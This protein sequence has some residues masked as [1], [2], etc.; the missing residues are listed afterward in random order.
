MVAGGV[1]APGSRG[2][3]S[4]ISRASTPRAKPSADPVAVG[5]GPGLVLSAVVLW[6]AR[7]LD[8]AVAQLRAEG[9][10]IKREDVVRLFPPEGLAPQLPDPAAVDDDVG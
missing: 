2:R 10:G 8:A 1:S 6:N 3:R 5:S 9:Y 4:P 7:R